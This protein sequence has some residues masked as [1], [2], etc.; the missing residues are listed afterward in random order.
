MRIQLIGSCNSY[1]LTWPN[2]QFEK[3]A[4]AGFRNVEIL[5]GQYRM[6]CFVPEVMV[7]EPWY[8]SWRVS[9]A[10]LKTLLHQLGLNPIYLLCE[11]DFLGPFGQELVKRRVDFAVKLGAT[12]LGIGQPPKSTPGSVHGLVRSI[13]RLADYAAERN[14][15]L[16]IES[17]CWVFRNAE[18]S[19]AMLSRI[20]RPNVKIMYNLAHALAK[21]DGIKPED[22]VVALGGNL[23]GLFLKDFGGSKP[24]GRAPYGD[25]NYNWDFPPLGDGLVDFPAVFERLKDFPG[26][27]P[28]VLQLEGGPHNEGYSLDDYQRDVRK[29][30]AYLRSIGVEF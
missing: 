30:L 10:D 8:G 3:M 1:G 22:E 18:T 7:D 24:G 19:N 28:C 17:L 21:N 26:D 2:L 23:G 4:E 12:L 25:T 9:I 13:Q 6:H 20:R 14:V 16:L 29:A 11:C 15:T 5:C 27:L